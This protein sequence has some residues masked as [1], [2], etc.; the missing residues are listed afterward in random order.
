[1]APSA[2]LTDAAR[3][4]PGGDFDAPDGFVVKPAPGYGGN[5]VAVIAHANGYPTCPL[6]SRHRSY[7]VQRFYRTPTC[8][9]RHS[10]GMRESVHLVHGVFLLPDVGT[11]TYGGTFTRLGRDPIVGSEGD[12]ALFCEPE[13]FRLPLRM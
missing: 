8:L 3:R 12:V 10:D 4:A 1:M 7:V 5:G 11:L 9:L 2:Q 6:S 13:W